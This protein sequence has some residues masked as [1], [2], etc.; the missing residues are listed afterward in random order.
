MRA[1]SP[2]GL[3]P[4]GATSPRI[5]MRQ[6]VGSWQSL[7]NLERAASAAAASPAVEAAVA[8]SDTLGKPA[9][10]RLTTGSARWQVDRAN[11]LR[12]RAAP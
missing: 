2:S 10:A 4:R 5:A 3:S 8:P 7:T 6:R 9:G 12:W 1:A 11:L